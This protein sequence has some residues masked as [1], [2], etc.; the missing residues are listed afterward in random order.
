VNIAA[1]ISGLTGP[2]EVLVS[3]IVRGLGR[4]SAEVV[5][6]DRG[7]H[8]LKG[9][10][11]SVR[12]YAVQEKSAARAALPDGL[13]AREVEVLRLIAAGRTNTEI[14]DEL[15]LSVRTVARHITNI[16]TKI[17]ARNKAEATDYVHQRGLR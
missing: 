4:T 6:E 14:A 8:M 9:V 11:D 2:G 12:V 17:G 1:R 16:Y 15:T 5:F 13:T 10:S 3:D 7:E